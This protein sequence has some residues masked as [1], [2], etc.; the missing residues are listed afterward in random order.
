MSIDDEIQ[1]NGKVFK[2]Y[3]LSSDYKWT[4]YEDVY[5]RVNNLSNGLLSLGLKSNDKIVLFAE[6]R[7]EWLVS[8]FACFKI[9]V[10]VVTLYS[11][12]GKFVGFVFF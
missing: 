3:S 7:P 9:K 6:T 8:A 10:P 2:K 5:A 1:L 11:T 12:L 4:T